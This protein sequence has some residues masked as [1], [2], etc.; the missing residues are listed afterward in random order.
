MST[1]L[2]LTLNP[3]LDMA[4]RTPQVRPTHKLR[5]TTAEHYPGGGGI[6]V[7]RV[8]HRLG[9][10]VQA[11]YLA[12]GPTGERL[13]TL[14]QAEGVQTQA[15]P[16]AGQTRENFSVI[17]DSTGQEFRFVLPGPKVQT[18]EWQA[19]LHGLA[20]VQPRPQW[21]VASGS[22]PPGVPD[23]FYAQ[24][25]RQARHQ[26]QQLVLDTSG[27]ALSSALQAGV[28]LLKVSLRELRELTGQALAQPAQW[29]IAAHSLVAQGQAQMV[30]LSLGEQ[31]ALLATPAG[32]WQ[33][34][35]LTVPTDEGTTGAG[36]CFLAALVWALAQDHPPAQALAWGVAGGTAALLSGGTRLAQPHDI[37]RLQPQ[38]RVHSVAKL[39]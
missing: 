30:A 39:C 23:D 19:C 3:A 7:A 14:L 17:E 24:L 9:S 1:F 16:I 13:Q 10:P 26:N 33:A 2:T 36:D 37:H 22:L 6:N 12:G 31:G 11:W 28:G 32:V 27:P 34:A 20:A 25:A 38:V 35:A 18:A 4:T 8:L 15:Q 21:L 5:C 29:A